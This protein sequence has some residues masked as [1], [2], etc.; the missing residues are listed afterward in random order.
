MNFYPGVGYIC[1]IGEYGLYTI[2]AVADSKS[3]MRYE[4]QF[5][6]CGSEAGGGMKPAAIACVV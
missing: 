4:F 1:C 3:V 5:L 2:K 6:L